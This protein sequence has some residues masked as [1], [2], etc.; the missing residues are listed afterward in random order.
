MYGRFVGLDIGKYEV[1][2]S[3]I[4]RGLRDVQLLQTV[5][6]A[7]TEGPGY[8]SE[9]FKDNSLPRGDIAVSL[10][11]NP[12]SIRIIQ[13]PFSDPKKIDQIYRYELENVSTFDPTEKIHSYHMIKNESGSEALACVFEKD[14][15]GTLLDSFNTVGIDPK[16]ITYSPLAFGVLNDVLEGERPVLLIDMGDRGIGF[17]LFDHEGLLRVRSSTKPLESFFANLRDR[18]GVSDFEFDYREDLFNNGGEGRRKD[19]MAPLVNEIKKTIQFFEIEVNLT[20]IQLNMVHMFQIDTKI[21]LI[22]YH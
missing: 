3:L 18:A 4:K 17:S 14:Q 2:V 16:V 7:I 9:V 6:T 10:T 8:L 13:F 5:S 1:R 20:Y 11:E 19:C 21:L 15:V 12:I 22:H